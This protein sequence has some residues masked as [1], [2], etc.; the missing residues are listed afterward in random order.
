LLTQDRI[1]ALLAAIA[2]TLRVNP[3][4]LDTR[5]VTLNERETAAHVHV[6]YGRD[7]LFAKVLLT[8]RAPCATPHFLLAP[9]DDA[10]GDRRAADHI[11]CERESADRLR[12]AAEGVAIRVPQMRA[13][14]ESERVMV[15]DRVEGTTLE[16]VLKSGRHAPDGC[17]GR[18]IGQALG[19][20]LL[21][22]HRQSTNRCRKVLPADCARALAPTESARTEY[23]P[24]L[25]RT[26]RELDALA[27][28]SGGVELPVAFVH[29]DLS[30]S[31][32]MWDRRTQS[33]A[34]VDFEHCRDDLTVFDLTA[35]IYSVRVSL[36]WPWVRP[37]V[38]REWEAGFRDG[39]RDGD[40]RRALA[41][42]FAELMAIA[43]VFGHFLPQR[44]AARERGSSGLA[45]VQRVLYRRFVKSRL[46][47]QRLPDITRTSDVPAADMV[48]R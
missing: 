1:D 40:E 33:V 39:Y 16:R 43:W 38:V 27:G 20:F 8:P 45:R 14:S 10:T 37:A 32:L 13:V 42:R 41:Y 7:P 46:L 44:L 31:N 18:E 6:D 12:L 23:A 17:G 19:A 9:S 47:A 22:V 21:R 26:L 48:T 3:H 5:A 29:G 30:L 24:M 4:D 2:R 11:A 25:S 34:I 36:L 15:W 35:W 28:A